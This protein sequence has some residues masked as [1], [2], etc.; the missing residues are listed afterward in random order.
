MSRK[1]VFSNLLI[2]LVLI[3]LLLIPSGSR[4][5]TGPAEDRAGGA[6]ERLNIVLVADGAPLPGGTAHLSFSVTPLVNIPD[7]D[8]K[9]FLPQGVVMKQGSA[10]ETLGSQTA[11]QAV[12]TDRYLT[13]SAPGTYKIAV[14]AT[15]HP[16]PSASYSAAGVLFFVIDSTS[17]Y[18]TDKDPDARPPVRSGLPEQVT[19]FPASAPSGTDETNGG[20][21]C[22][23][24]TGHIERTDRPVTSSGYGSNV[25]VPVVNAPVEIRE[26]D[27]LFDDDYGT[28]L[29]DG[30][31]NFSKA[32]C[33]DDG[34][35]D[36]ELEIYYRLFTERR[37]TGD[38][39]VYVED[40]SWIDE[41][42]EYDTG[43][44]ASEGGTIDIDL[45][46]DMTWSGM[47]N[48]VDAMTLAK[49][50]WTSSGDSYGEDVEV[51]WETGY[52]D[53][54]SYF[55]PFW[56]EITVADD[57]SDPDQWDDSVLMH[58]WGHSAD[59]YYS[60]DDNPGGDHFINQLVDDDELAW[61]E[62]YPDYYQS[63]V[64]AA[65]GYAFASWYLDINGSE[66]GGIMLDFEPYDTSVGSDLISTFNE[67]AIA[68]ALWDLNDSIDDGQ[69]TVAH[70]HSMVQ[71][72]YTSEAFYD[73]AY[74]FFDDTCNFDTYMRG[75]IDADKPQDA[76]TAAAVL[77]NTGY[78]LPASLVSRPVQTGQGNMVLATDSY[79]P[80]EVYR[81]WKQL[82]YVADNSSSMSGPKY[83]AIK[84]LFTEAVNDLGDDPEGTEFSLEQFNNTTSFNSI[85]FAGQFFPETLID[86]INALNPIPNADPNCEVYALRALGQAIDNKEKGDVWLFTDGDTIQS[87][88]V[89]AIR[90]SLNDKQLRA[91]VALMGVCLAASEASLPDAPI[92]EDMLMELSEEE[93]QTLM[94]DRLLAG[95]A[96]AAL[97]PMGQEVPGGLVP[98]LL[99]ALNSGG[100]FLYVDSSQVDAAADILRA[101][102][103]NSAGAG[104]W[105]DYVSDEATYRWDT[106]A[107]FEYNWIDATDGTNE[108]NPN[109]DSYLE[110]PLPASFSY[111]NLPYSSVRVFQ[112]G[113]LAFGNETYATPYNTILPSF[114]LPN[115]TLYPFWDDLT[116]DFVIPGPKGADDPDCCTLGWIYTEQAGDWFVIEYFDYLSYDNSTAY[117][118]YFEIL[119]NP[120]TGEIRYQYLDV[121]N[122]AAGS[123]IGL[124][125]QTGYS[126]IQ[127]SYND[128]NGASDN[129]GYKFTPAPPQ[130]TKT[131]SITVDSTMQSVGFLLTGYSGT[132]EPLLVE[133]PDGTDISCASSGVL[134][135]DLDLVQYVQVNTNGVTG[136][137]HATVDAG[138]SGEGT[139]SFTSFAASPLA[140]ES[141]FDHTLSTSAH[142]IFV[143]LT[144]PVDGNVLTG[145]FLL[146]NGDPFGGNFMFYDDGLHDDGEEG[147][148]LFGS[149]VFDPPGVGS[150]F[151]RLTGLLDGEAFERID[152]TPYTFSLLE[153]TSLGDGDNFGEATA[154]PFQVTNFDT[155]DHCYWVS[156]DAPPGWY[157]DFVF[158][159]IV[160]ADAGQTETVYFTT[161]MGPGTT[162]F[163][164][165]G[166]TGTFTISLTEW[167]KGEISD[168]DAASVTRRRAPAYVMI[169]KFTNYI[170][171]NGD[172]AEL[173]IYV[174]DDQFYP[175]AD[176][177][178]VAFTAVNG[179]VS[180]TEGT[181]VNGYLYTTFTSGPNVG[182]GEVTATTYGPVSG[183]IEID[184]SD[185]KP[186]EI[187]L[188]LSAYH[189]P[190][191]GA[192]QITLTAVVKDRWGNPMPGQEVHIGV[193]EDGQLGTIEGGEVVS[194][195]TDA[196]GEFVAVFTSGEIIGIVG[197]R[198]ELYYDKGSGL[199]LVHDDRK[200]IN[201]GS[202]V[203]LPIIVK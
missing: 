188:S 129:M 162:N 62:G 25:T 147:D 133:K 99:T 199:E 122:G 17:S 41:K 77:Q 165:S 29:T 194:G 185:P 52:G 192:S 108:G 102:I 69:D 85:E 65:N 34:W 163:L 158:L 43:Y 130:P 78:T 38:G 109:Y 42:Y 119:L 104:R 4:A 11:G 35:F 197:V 19:V 64:R 18:V 45:S 156:Y 138:S 12:Q 180:P 55:D 79:T 170:R 179:T 71:D 10:V 54:G 155:V 131:Y 90:Q 50:L 92:S 76:A 82:T 87:P 191:D 1:N 200:V 46:L 125:N 126:G 154:L 145:F 143:N 172:T 121:P 14:S 20:D 2:L 59:D 137:W 44:V 81:W 134:C 171:P 157:I 176:G 146:N 178:Y 168:S 118:N 196:N 48:I 105:S 160:C 202:N 173:A 89:E 144:E 95:Q 152:P 190:P 136:V 135:L 47:F 198:A 83:D 70:G 51:H 49:T 80:A 164:P 15:F 127:V 117:N 114:F 13:F 116:P 98:Y 26:S 53:A 72:V 195:V 58:E 161:Y 101:Q 106:L 183:S 37:G 123:T 153:V 3:T 28:V 60:C 27:T 132:F 7:L 86:P 159:P 141:G 140:V 151:L 142:S 139:F 68:A 66:A 24:V 57:P 150:A 6:R 96:R 203:H 93:Q 115:N 33:D 149:D 110:I 184:I 148:G 36:D 107:T 22:F 91:S 21:P 182:T 186:T 56:N 23:T 84:T 166:T 174:V 128:V 73:I 94:A 193:E 169:E 32:F 111:Y 67:L 39:V 5:Q 187:T 175:V 16:F 63:A 74:G 124:E 75:W 61:G 113:Y 97:G 167:E 100:Q 189:V 9:W 40:S 181:T 201:V 103:T 177:T 112:D 31:G 8:I 88:S 120:T 30:N